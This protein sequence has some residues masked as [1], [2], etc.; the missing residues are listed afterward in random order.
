MAR[1]KYKIEVFQKDKNNDYSTTADYTFTNS[2]TFSA[3][4]SIETTADTFNVSIENTRS[5]SSGVTSYSMLNGTE[6]K[7]K[8]DDKIIIY[9]KSGTTA[10]TDSDI[11]FVGL[12]KEIQYDVTVDGR[13]M[14]IKGVNLLE[15]LTK[16]TYSAVYPRTGVTS[17]SD[18]VQDLINEANDFQMRSKSTGIRAN[19][20]TWKSDNDVTTAVVNY[21]AIYRP[22]FELIAEVSSQKVNREFNAIYYL[23]SANEFV[24]KQKSA[25]LT[26]TLTEGRDFLS[27]KVQYKVWQVV[28]AVIATAGKD[29]YDKSILCFTYN[30]NS[31]AEFGLKWHEGIEVADK[32]SEIKRTES[33]KDAF[34]KGSTSAFPVS[35]S[36]TWTF[37]FKTRNA[38]GT[39]TSTDATATSDATYNAAIKEEA[40]W[41]A[42]EFLNGYLDRSGVATPKIDLSLDGTVWESGTDIIGNTL[43]ISN[44]EK[45]KLDLPSFGLTSGDTLNLRVMSVN[46]SFGTRGWNVTLSVETDIEDAISITG[47]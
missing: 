12:I 2:Q 25:T 38:D 21:Q 31:A 17:A 34:P 10:F 26:A 4:V 9:L 30:E 3:D 39:P 6:I 16:S 32:A 40:R 1:I 18:I 47:H 35:Y 24:W 41:Q 15:H 29:C 37:S 23:N 28:N 46:H 36:P 43:K 44:G 42:V 27:C 8:N 33:G 11:I 14:N 13:K 20:I 5:R 19:Q 45:V 22:I 7:I